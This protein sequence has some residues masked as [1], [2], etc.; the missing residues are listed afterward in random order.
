[1]VEIQAIFNDQHAGCLFGVV[2]EFLR[3]LDE[4]P[5][6]VSSAMSAFDMQ[7]TALAKERMRFV[8]WF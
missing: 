8:P 3:G 1:M 6:E 4:Q 7:G 2:F 5:Y